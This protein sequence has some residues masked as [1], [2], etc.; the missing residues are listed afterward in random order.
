MIEDTYV[1]MERA[2]PRDGE[3]SEYVKV[4]KRLQY[5]NVIP[6]GKDNDNP[7]LYIR[8]H[9]VQY[10]DGNKASLYANTFS[11][12]LSSQVDEESNIFML[13]DEIVY[14]SVYGTENMHQGFL[15]VSRNVWN[16]RRKTTK[17]R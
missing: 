1:D 16:K 6:I 12:N 8:I 4:T 3:V 9:E 5:A 13:F 11:E 14:Q 15:I 7:M 10:L 2:L 17:E